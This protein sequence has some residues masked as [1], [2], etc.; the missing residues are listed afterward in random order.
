MSPHRYHSAKELQYLAL[1]C[2]CKHLLDVTHRT[3]IDVDELRKHLI[4]KL[5]ASIRTDILVWVKTLL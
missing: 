3:K 2:F 4:K 5:P 1:D